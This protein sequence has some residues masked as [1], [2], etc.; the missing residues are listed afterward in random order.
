ME[1]TI[2]L[3]ENNEQAKALV[4]YLKNLSFVKIKKEKKT[5]YNPD[6][7]KKILER[8]DNAAKGN[9]TTIDPNDLW[10]SLNLK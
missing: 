4:K 3:E 1:L 5:N 9:V 8:A 7:V 10:G 6:F 2:T